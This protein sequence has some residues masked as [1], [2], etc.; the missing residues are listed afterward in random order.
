M[1][2][3]LDP[4]LGQNGVQHDGGQAAASA[5]SSSKKEGYTGE[6]KARLRKVRS[7]RIGSH[8]ITARSSELC[9]RSPRLRKEYS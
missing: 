8:V 3:N 4:T 5:P 2:A 1:Y 7:P 9:R 6:V